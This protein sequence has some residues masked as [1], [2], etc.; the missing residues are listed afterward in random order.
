MALAGV[1]IAVGL[2]LAFAL[3]RTVESFLFGTSPTDP[4]TFA[5]IAA[6]LAGVALLAC[7]APARRA[8]RLDPMKV[9]RQE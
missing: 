2:A 4:L 7:L 9:L 1:G 8:A 6:L 5:G 3:A